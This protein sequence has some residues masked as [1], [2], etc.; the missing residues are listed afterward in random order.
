[1]QILS[2]NVGSRQ[3]LVV[4]SKTVQTGIY[5]IPATGAIAVSKMGLQDDVHIEPRKMGMEHS[6]VYAYPFEHYH[7]W[8]QVLER[9]E[10]FP[11]GQFGENLT[12][13]GLLEEDVRIGD[14]FRFGNTV[15][16]VAHPRIPCAKLNAKMGLRFAPMFLASRRVG[17][18]FRVLE[19]GTVQKGDRIELLERDEG[20]PT[21]EEFVRVANF[22]YWDAEGLR[23]LLQARD[24]LP[25]WREMIEA[26]LSKAQSSGSWHGTREFEVVRR[27]QESKNALSLY[28]HCV[29][30]RPLS[31]FHG[32]QQLMIVLGERGGGHQERKACYLSS[33]PN[34]L[35]SYRVTVLVGDRAKK[36]CNV[37]THL[38]SLQVGNRVLCTAPHG[39]VRSMPEESMEA[40]SPVLISQGLGLAPMLSMLYE[41]ERYQTDA[42]LF[43]EPDSI[44]PQT[45]LGE[46]QQL[47]ER[48]PRFKLF[49]LDRI[50][51][52]RIGEEIQLGQ[53][54][55]N[56]AGSK[57]FN[58][59]MEIEFMA[60][61]I[62]PGAL[63]ALKVD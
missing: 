28:L 30:G 59:R 17:Y 44:V 26:K 15:L 3:P 45:L 1:M 18:Y 39:N 29:R 23:H 54:N 34:E 40:R 35:S 47:I 5:K 43:H 14:I 4:K 2:V 61:N 19:E 24:L 58:M 41:L 60:L 8:Q 42:V 9:D 57:H 31:P 56:I 63:L 53:S 49:T 13:E 55:I 10:P 52:Q 32:G 27:D 22:E 25:A 6:A 11:I 7:Y 20:S 62:S 50:T 38:A 16:Q 36:D 21:M 37:S 48:N 33:N 46:L 12:V 51:A